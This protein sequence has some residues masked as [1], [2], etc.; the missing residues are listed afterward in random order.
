[1]VFIS[2]TSLVVLGKRRSKT[3]KKINTTLFFTTLLLLVGCSGKVEDH[4]RLID[5]LKGYDVNRISLE[6][7]KEVIEVET[8]DPNF[9]EI[10]KLT[11]NLKIRSKYFGDNLYGVPIKITFYEG[12]SIIFEVSSGVE[13]TI[14][15]GTTFNTSIKSRIYA[16]KLDTIL[17]SYYGYDQ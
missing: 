5:A 10:I 16:E 15:N 11:S 14:V 12:N 9:I 2:I 1:M 17:G 13:Y 3:Y 4:Q 7:Y 8:S 6:H